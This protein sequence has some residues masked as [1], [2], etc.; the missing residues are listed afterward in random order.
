MTVHIVSV[1]F[2]VQFRVWKE[3]HCTVII[4]KPK[5][6]FL[7]KNVIVLGCSQFERKN[8]EVASSDDNRLH[9]IFHLNFYEGYNSQK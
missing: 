1:P 6:T 5:T 4:E 8:T 3:I 2:Q 9:D 7:D